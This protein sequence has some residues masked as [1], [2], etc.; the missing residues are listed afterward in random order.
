MS[1]S[2]IEW[3]FHPFKNY[4]GIDFNNQ[5]DNQEEENDLN[6]DFVS[7]MISSENQL[8]NFSND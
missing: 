6:N 2:E 7:L 1:H 5:Y 3:T 8:Y 4:F